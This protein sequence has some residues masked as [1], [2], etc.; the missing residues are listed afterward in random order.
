[1]LYL[2][3][4]CATSFSGKGQK[5]KID[6]EPTKVRLVG[7]KGKGQGLI[8]PDFSHSQEPAAC[9]ENFEG[10][11]EDQLGKTPLSVTQT[12]GDRE[13]GS[14]AVYKVMPAAQEASDDLARSTKGRPEGGLRHT[15][16]LSTSSGSKTRRS[17]TGGSMPPRS[18]LRRSQRPEVTSQRVDD[19]LEVADAEDYKEA[20]GSL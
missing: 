17:H 11:D 18:S 19:L 8:G 6:F 9:L 10:N 1:M 5:I 2:L 15:N 12:A 14:G 7:S 4:I 3:A 16:G 20:D 13:K